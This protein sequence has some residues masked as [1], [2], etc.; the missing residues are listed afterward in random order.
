M[1]SKR[2]PFR[3]SSLII[4]LFVLGLFV[5]S[6]YKAAKM[7]MTHD[8]SS[9]FLNYSTTNV[10]SCFS[11]PF[12]WG[13]ANNHMLNTFLFQQTVHWFGLSEWSLR[14]PNVVLHLLYLL[15]SCYLVALLTSNSLL[16]ITG[17]VL[18][19]R[20]QKVTHGVIT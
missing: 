2:I 10:W 11:D 8:E 3:I 18:L 14:L 17:F 15:S 16:R 9:T 13:T 6:N 19:T 7:G 12:C 4:G 1:K 5:F 20:V